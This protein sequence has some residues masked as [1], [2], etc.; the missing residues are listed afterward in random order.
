MFFTTF[1]THVMEAKGSTIIDTCELTSFVRAGYGEPFETFVLSGSDY[2]AAPFDVVME[3]LPWGRNCH[4]HRRLCKAFN[5]DNTAHNLA[6]HTQIQ[7]PRRHLC[8]AVSSSDNGMSSSNSS[9]SQQHPEVTVEL[10]HNSVC[11]TQKTL[12][13]WWRRIRLS[14]YFNNVATCGFRRGWREKMVDNETG[15]GHFILTDR[16][17]V[18]RCIYFPFRH[19]VFQGSALAFFLLHTRCLGLSRDSLG[20]SI[21]VNCSCIPD[22]AHNGSQVHRGWV[23]NAWQRLNTFAVNARCD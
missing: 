13:A 18:V 17:S 9:I 3:T 6:M 22:T 2:L 4:W 19:G 8:C 10:H 21:H 5:S 16:S 15:R 1:L 11:T 14:T 12:A 20:W 7:Y 23:L